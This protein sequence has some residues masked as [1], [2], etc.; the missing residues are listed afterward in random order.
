MS[1]R[2]TDI[3]CSLMSVI[4]R[5]T[6]GMEVCAQVGAAFAAASKKVH[7]M[8]DYVGP[9]VL[10]LARY[11]VSSEDAM[12]QVYVEHRLEC[13][14][15]LMGIK[16]KTNLYVVLVH[17]GTRTYITGAFLLVPKGAHGRE[18]SLIEYGGIFKE[19]TS[20]TDAEY[21]EYTAKPRPAHWSLDHPSP[22]TGRVYVR[23]THVL[24][25]I[26][27]FVTGDDVLDCSAVIHT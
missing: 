27:I 3:F 2:K 26:A 24:I 25:G 18:S 15:Q 16:V 10:P 17:D 1:F 7:G 5:N 21:A 23:L 22:V 19:V 13:G 9:H 12:N 4:V 14:V 20:M 11:M 6:S 8:P